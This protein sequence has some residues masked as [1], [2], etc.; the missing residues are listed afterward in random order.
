[1]HRRFAPELKLDNRAC[2]ERTCSPG[3][4]QGR[5]RLASDGAVNDSIYALDSQAAERR[6]Q[7]VEEL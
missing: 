3:V 1:M 2:R 4:R 7:A 5:L 6:V